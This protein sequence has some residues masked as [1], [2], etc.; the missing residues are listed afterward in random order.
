MARFRFRC[1]S[2]QGRYALEAG[3]FLGEDLRGSTPLDSRS[4]LEL[5][6]PDETPRSWFA[7]LW[8][9][10]VAS[11]TSSGGDFEI[12]VDEHTLRVEAQSSDFDDPQADPP[13]PGR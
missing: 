12:L 7:T 9:H 10:R 4:W 2:R 13:A 6:T 8:H 11:G 5:T 1:L 3:V